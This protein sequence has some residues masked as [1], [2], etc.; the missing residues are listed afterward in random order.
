MC[1]A[2]T[3]V[4][5]ATDLPKAGL[6]DQACVTSPEINIAA[7]SQ[8]A[9]LS[10]SNQSPATWEGICT[11]RRLTYHP[12]Q[13]IPGRVNYR[14]EAHIRLNREQASEHVARRRPQVLFDS[15]EYSPPRGRIKP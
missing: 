9:W 13:T 5:L 8:T 7:A 15:A 2:S 1:Q 12:D 14:G 11:S 4:F 6:P 10:W 3:Y